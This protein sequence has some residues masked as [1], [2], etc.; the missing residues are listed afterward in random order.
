MDKMPTSITHEESSS[1]HGQGK[2]IP[3]KA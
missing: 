2:V 1:T 3:L